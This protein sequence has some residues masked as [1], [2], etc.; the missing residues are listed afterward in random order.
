MER[1]FLGWRDV[2]KSA[3]IERDEGRLFLYL[4]L[5]NLTSYSTTLRVIS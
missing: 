2:G 3:Y 5:L 4:F 1:R